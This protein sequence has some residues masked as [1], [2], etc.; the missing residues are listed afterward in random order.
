MNTPVTFQDTSLRKLK[1]TMAMFYVKAQS[2]PLEGVSLRSSPTEKACQTPMVGDSR[3]N[4]GSSESQ[5]RWGGFVMQQERVDEAS[6]RHA[7]NV[8]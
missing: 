3:E 7:S 1:S 4:L 5:S 6:K 2:R 8:S